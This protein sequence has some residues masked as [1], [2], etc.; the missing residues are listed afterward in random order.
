MIQDKK[1]KRRIGIFI[2]FDKDGIVDE[3]EEY[4][5][6]S[7]ST[8]LDRLIVVINGNIRNDALNC[9][10]QY[11]QEVYFRTNDGFDGGAYKEILLNYL[12]R[13]ELLKFDELLLVNDTF[14]GPFYSWNKVFDRTERENYDF[15]GLTKHVVSY[16]LQFQRILNEHVQGYFLVFTNK[17]FRE[18][19]F[20]QFWEEM[21]DIHS[22]EDAIL[23][24]E[25]PLTTYFHEAGFAYGVYTDT[26]PQKDYL[27]RKEAVYSTCC[28]NLLQ[29]YDFPILKKK[30]GVSFDNPQTIP[31]LVFISTKTDYNV[32]YI[33]NNA[34]RV[35]PKAKAF[36]RLDDFFNRY[37]NIYIY[38]RGQIWKSIEKFFLLREWKIAGFIETDPKD[39]NQELP[40]SIAWKDFRLDNNT[41]IIVALGVKNSAEVKK[42]VKD[43]NNILFLNE[44]NKDKEQYT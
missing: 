24:F 37:E 35:L 20:Y 40:K 13:E 44:T 3:S 26:Y 15:W 1:R 43:A 23:N 5:I 12:H 32:N 16:N 42:L 21:P 41:G 17:V 30:D 2:Y 18:A 11:T 9:I 27:N 39:D 4:L 33:W 6:E 14:Y 29:D 19:V 38:G 10:K 36:F 34:R 28:C 25:V 7:F 22:H 31:A 8:F